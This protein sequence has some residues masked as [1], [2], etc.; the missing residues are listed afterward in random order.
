VRYSGLKFVRY[1]DRLDKRSPVH[2]LLVLSDLCNQNC[3]FCAYRDPGYSSSQLFHI[4][5]DYN[6]NRKLP[7]KKVQEILQDC[8]SMGVKAV[9]FTGGGEPTVHPQFQDSVD[10]ATRL[11]LKY[12]LITNGVLLSKFDV[13]MASW[14][15]I[16]LD[17]AKPETYAKIRQVPGGHFHKALESIR[18]HKCGVGFVVTNDNW[19]EVKEAALLAKSLGASN[20]RIAGQFNEGG[21]SIYSNYSVI[22]RLCKET[23]SLSGDGFTV[24]N[25]LGRLESLTPK[26]PFC[27]YQYLTTY[28][29]ADQNMYRCC[30]YAYNPHGLIGSVKEKRFS[31]A[32]AEAN[33][34]LDATECRNC[35]F[36]GINEG[37]NEALNEDESSVFV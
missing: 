12:G 35:N 20:I 10:E 1:L 22:A 3:S 31:E 34:K 2:V 16:S 23:E 25:N 19:R 5:G 11:G 18:K 9:S 33:L 30:V 8:A 27:G 4:D 26:H 15:R 36:I 6:P 32:W 28:I 17:A 13:S 29:G 14:I 7:F 24:H 37:I 21:L